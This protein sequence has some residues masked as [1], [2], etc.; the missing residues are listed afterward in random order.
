M[1]DKT[2]TAT[3]SRS[4][5][6]IP[7]ERET[8]LASLE[9]IVNA[10]ASYDKNRR[11]I[12]RADACPDFLDDMLLSERDDSDEK[13][14]QLARNAVA[15]MTLHSAKGLEFPRVYLVG[16]EEGIL[17]H[18]RSLAMENDAAIDEERRLCYVGVTRAQRTT[19]ALVR[20][21]PPQMGQA[22]AHHSQP[23]SLRNDRPGGKLPAAT[24]EA[25]AAKQKKPTSSRRSTRKAARR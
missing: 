4:S 2:T 9:E 21:H 1:L 14:S 22:A 16:M 23:V 6:P 3:R 24:A 20:A 5:I 18:K 8:R 11:A 7:T 17:P 25:N 13:E 10:A 12:E 19:D 15:L